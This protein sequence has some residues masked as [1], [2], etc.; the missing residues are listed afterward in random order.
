M[1]IPKFETRQFETS[2]MKLLKRFIWACLCTYFIWQNAKQWKNFNFSFYFMFVWSWCLAFSNF[3]GLLLH[4]RKIEKLFL[5]LNSSLP[6]KY[7]LLFLSFFNSFTSIYY[8]LIWVIR[9]IF[10]EFT[11]FVFFTPREWFDS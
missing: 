6:Y 2:K 3:F 8:F 11:Y 7:V 10:Q 5:Q 4:C 9:G 1:E